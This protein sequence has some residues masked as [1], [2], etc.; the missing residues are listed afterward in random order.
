M[1]TFPCS[2]NLKIPSGK[3]VAVVGQVGSGKSSLLSALLGEMD[4][5]SGRVNVHV[6]TCPQTMLITT[7]GMYPTFSFLRLCIVKV[8]FSLLTKYVGID[9]KFKMI[10]WRKKNSKRLVWFFKHNFAFTPLPFQNKS[11]WIRLRKNT[12]TY[13]YQPHKFSMLNKIQI[14]CKGLKLWLSRTFILTI[15][16]CIPG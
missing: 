2:I 11:F 4:K 14:K 5:L 3:L 10:F 7:K 12:C 16:F 6:S 1:L 13:S 9:K 8:N 15:V